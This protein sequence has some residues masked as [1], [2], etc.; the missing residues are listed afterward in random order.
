MTAASNRAGDFGRKTLC[1]EKKICFDISEINI[2]YFL[3][4][5]VKRCLSKKDAG[6]VDNPQN[7]FTASSWR[8]KR[9]CEHG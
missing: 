8:E 6:L 7:A 9:F 1:I 5:R 4:L 3:W 2:Q